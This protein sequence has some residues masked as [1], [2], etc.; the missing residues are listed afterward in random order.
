MSYFIC[1]GC[2]EKHQI[3]TNNGHARP[4]ALADARLLCKIPLSP[5]IAQRVDSSHPLLNEAPAGPLA[6]AFLQLADTI[7]QT[8]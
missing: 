6:T 1:P 4:D 2:G 7:L 5:L 3:F 8:V